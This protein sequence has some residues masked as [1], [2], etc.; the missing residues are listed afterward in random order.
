MYSGLQP[1]LETAAYPARA[2]LG[3]C[4]GSVPH[5]SSLPYIKFPLAVVFIA[6][7]LCPEQMQVTPISITSWMGAVL[8][9]H[10]SIDRIA[11]SWE[12]RKDAEQMAGRK[13]GRCQKVVKL[14]RFM[15]TSPLYLVVLW[16]LCSQEPLSKASGS[17]AGVVV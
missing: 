4:C 6:S 10:L 14:R 5:I 13:A 9:G 15:N 2:F 12:R 3:S 7:M 17:V 1:A 16:C 8:V 11:L